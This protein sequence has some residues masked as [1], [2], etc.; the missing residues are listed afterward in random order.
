MRRIVGLLFVAVSIV[1][2]SGQL[3]AGELYGDPADGWAY[4]Y[5]GEEAD[6]GD[7]DSGF[8][9]LDGTWQ[10][11]N[12]SDQLD[13]AGAFITDGVGA[14]G[15]IL[16]ISEGN[17]NFLRLED[18]GDP[19]DDGFSEPS[20]RKLFFIHD[21]GEDGAEDDIMDTGVTLSFRARIPT[22]GPL[23]SPAS[24]GN[25]YVLHDGGKS[26][27]TISQ[28]GADGTAATIS[29][30][31]ASEEEDQ[32]DFTGGGLAMNSSSGPDVTSGQVDWQGSEGTPNLHAVDDPTQWNE[33]WIN[34]FANPD[35][36][37]SHTV[38]VY[39]N[40]E[41]A[42]QEV[43]SVTAGPGRDA[44][45]NYIALGLGS[46]PQ[47]GALDVDFFGWAPGLLEPV[48]NGGGNGAEC[49]FDGSGTCDF[50]DLD[51]LLYTG[52]GSGDTKYDLDGSGT[53]DLGD[54]DAFLS[55]I[56][57]PLGDFTDDGAV[58]AADLNVVGGSWQADGI[59]SYTSG[60][61]NGDGMVNA[62]DLN[63]VGSNWQVGAAAPASAVVPEPS[64]GLLLM[65]AMS[66]L[67]LLRRKS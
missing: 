26:S 14:P 20:H 16:P 47:S 23:D 57:R 35:D 41:L 6:A 32:T 52:I 42:D 53:V 21:I 46:T 40:G 44:D 15:G 31:L 64:A 49:D 17:T 39:A 54:R 37:G 24:A 29:F 25:G 3:Q 45:G 13:S 4:I 59:T 5:H 10:H 65:L 11:D 66:G 1:L 62:T 12:G 27:F 43:Y 38:V 58:T 30:A 34:I 18:T 61:S 33:F 19:R 2:G 60:D 9:S 55:E 8:T 36:V 63:A 51:E 56:G 28:A 48:A 67:S 7:A 22:D 50:V